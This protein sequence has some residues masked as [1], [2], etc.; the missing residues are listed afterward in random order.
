MC[1]SIV[2]YI[3]CYKCVA[4]SQVVSSTHRYPQYQFLTDV[5]ISSKAKNQNT[6][7]DLQSL[8]GVVFDV[9]TLSMSDYLV[10][11]FSS[12]VREGRVGM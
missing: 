11:C 3:P 9:T 8:Y 6:R 7:Y 12:Q 1:K 2:M 5:E 4:C 10:C